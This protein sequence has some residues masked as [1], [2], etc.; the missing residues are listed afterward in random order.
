MKVYNGIL[1]KVDESD[2]K[3]LEK[4]PEKFWENIRE[5]NSFAFDGC[6]NLTSIEIPDGIEAIG[7][8]AFS[9]CPNLTSVKIPYSVKSVGNY[10]FAGCTNLTS[11]EISNG[12]KSI[13]DFAFRGCSNLTKID[14][15]NSVETIGD[16]AFDGCNG[17]IILNIPKNVK[18]MG[19]FSFF[20]FSSLTDIKLPNCVTIIKDSAFDSCTNLTSIEIPNSVE[21]IGDS[22]FKG[23]ANLTN[24]KMS[25]SVK[26]IGDYAFDGCT[27]LTSIELPNSLE[28]IGDFTFRDCTNLTKIN[29]P[30]SVETIG[31][32]AFSGCANLTNI[33]I[34]GN[35]KSIKN[36][37]FEGC[38]NL[39]SIEISDGVE[40]IGDYI[41]SNCENLKSINISKNVTQMGKW[42]F[43]ELSKLTNVRLPNCLTSIED[44]AFNNCA[45]LTN[46]EIPNSVKTIGDWAFNGCTNLTSIEIPNG[47]ET[48]G[49]FV[50]DGCTNLT[51]IEIPDSV[52]TIGNFTF[53]NCKKLIS[54]NIPKNVTQMGN[55]FFLGFSNLTDVRLPNCVKSIDYPAFK[56][57][58]NLAYIEIPDSVESISIDLYGVKNVKVRGKHISGDL[59]TS[60]VFN[61]IKSNPNINLKQLNKIYN[62]AKE[63]GL[64]KNNVKDFISLCYNLGMLE[65]KSVTLSVNNNGKII[66][67]PICDM[68]FTF[69]QGLINRN[70]IN[71]NELH[72]YLQDLKI[73][74]FDKNFAKFVMNKNNWQD[75][76][77]NLKLVSRVYEWFNL[78][79]NLDIE[80]NQNP[81]LP[82]TEENRYKILVYE[83]SENGIDR[84]HWRVP[85]FELLLKEFAE[86]R[87][88]GINNSRE[89]EIAE[90]ISK[91]NIYS[92]KHFDKAK[93]IDKE[94]IDKGVKDILTKHVY[95]DRIKSLDDYREKTKA[96]REEII[97]D[98]ST[99]LSEQVEDTSSVFTYSVLSKSSVENFA[100]G[101]M[102]SCCAT[103]Y[104]A[105]AGA[106]RAM[107]IH[108]DIQPLVI[109]D[110]NN[111]IVSFGIIYVNREK[112]YAVVND[113][114]VN[115]FYKDKDEQRRAIYD[116]AMEGV[117]AFVK[118]YNIENPNAPIK[119]VTCGCSPNW[120]A[121]NDFIIKHPKSEILTAP[122]FDDFK[123]AGSGSWS[124]DWH[125]QQYE[126]LNLEGG[127]E[128]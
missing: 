5:I 28:I 53:S 85:T 76:K 46:I 82:K 98:A 8:Y 75:L 123:Y 109:R 111:T 115:Y 14:I 16:Y 55:W 15:P 103:L 6:T 10:T 112:G 33:E 116:K 120:K 126:I 119:R 20:G 108:P 31:N 79:T 34:P 43:S 56:D 122:D 91:Y 37:A 47:V 4:N 38:A 54:I 83:T 32:R 30:N 80:A 128:K 86:N 117:K 23:C 39:T 27:N 68:A 114:E 77:Q 25:S 9:D 29:I 19:K 51:N 40:R 60:E 52:K 17:L 110:F 44:S 65:D 7:N 18:Q 90:F 35:V 42:S 96:V 24:L 73:Q 100:M 121:I 50:F 36:Y 3:L 11:I 127:Y 22:A 95:Q 1:V 118:E 99:I 21:T 88:V 70:E 84:L 92:Q 58:P 104:G 124:G 45:S 81:F 113:F 89:K 106:M 67:V 2:I 107:I 41:L 26:S 59:L 57:C 12:L 101:C 71:L 125:E 66:Q 49:S 64:E 62:I 102:T 72:I 94:R 13:G 87:L 78:R 105:G 61:L 97:S 63:K 48:I 93:E 69:M 74:S